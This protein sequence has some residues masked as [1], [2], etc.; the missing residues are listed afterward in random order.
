MPGETSFGTR[1]L[2][3]SRLVLAES[4]FADGNQLVQLDHLLVSLGNFFRTRRHDRFGRF[5]SKHFVGSDLVADQVGEIRSVSPGHA[6]NGV[7]Q[8]VL[9]TW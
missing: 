6:S 1:D 8:A 4:L 5:Q 2:L 3:S 7:A 9:N